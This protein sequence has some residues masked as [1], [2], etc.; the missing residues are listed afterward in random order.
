M[1]RNTLD[2]AK[3]LYDKFKKSGNVEYLDSSIK[4]LNS[5]KKDL[6]SLNL[7]GLCYLDKEDPDKALEYFDQAYKLAKDD[8]SK[9]VIL[10]NKALCFFKKKNYVETYEI[11]K[12]VVS[13]RT[14]VRAHANRLLAK[15]CIVR[16]GKYLNEARSILESYDEPNE[17]LALVYILLSRSGEKDLYKKAIDIAKV[18][19]ND[20][21]LAEALL[22]SDEISD[23][24]ESLEIFRKIGDVS[25]EAKALFAL[26]SKKPELIYEAIQKLE[27]SGKGESAETLQ[28]LFEMYKRTNILDFLK[29]A[30]EIAKKID[31]KLFLARAYAELS[32]HENEIENLRKAVKYY[33]K[34]IESWQNK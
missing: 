30:I 16:G 18:L 2:E 17:D 14:S 21:L 22:S 27:E 29:R 28:L 6:N 26:S 19:K 8:E 31:N 5:L 34:Y 9:G 10:F 25:G 3:F 1:K 32:L 13:L 23:L 24:E 4:I 11:L 20:K 12:Q 15:V 33:E 7:L